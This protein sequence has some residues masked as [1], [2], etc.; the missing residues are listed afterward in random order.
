MDRA[1]AFAPKGLAERARRQL[2]RRGV[3]P[4]L[5]ADIESIPTLEIIRTLAAALGAGP[6]MVDRIWDAASHHFDAVVAHRIAPR[7]DGVVAFEYTALASFQGAKAQ[8]KPCVLHTPSL[9]NRA[10]RA[11]EEKEKSAWPELRSPHDA[12]FNA[13]FEVRQARREAGSALADLIVA[14]SSLTKRSHVAGGADPDKIAVVPLGAPPPLDQPG[15]GGGAGALQV[16]CQVRFILR[17][18]ASSPSDRRTGDCGRRE[19][20]PD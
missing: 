12:N 17:C 15:P 19:R 18:R 14:N 4:A 13:L 6:V 5:A 2:A 16:L 1:L 9:E 10:F 11:L 8:G 3:F 7:S 20:E